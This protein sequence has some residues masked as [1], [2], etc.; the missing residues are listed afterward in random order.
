MNR[1]LLLIIPALL[2]GCGD[3]SAFQAP[4]SVPNGTGAQVRSNMNN[5]LQAITTEQSGASAPSTTYPYQ[6]WIDTSTTPPTERIRNAANTAWVAVGTVSAT[7]YTAGN[8]DTVDT[9]HASATPGNSIIPVGDSAGRIAWGAKPAFRG[10]LVYNTPGTT[11]L[12]GFNSEVYDTDN[13]HST[14]GETGWLVVPAGVSKIRITA[15]GRLESGASWRM[16]VLKNGSFF[17]GG[18]SA[19]A[20]TFYHNL[21]TPVLSVTAGDFFE[22]GASSMTADTTG[23]ECWFAMEI[24]E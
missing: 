1:L 6:K 2:F 4:I 12:A 11:G 15:Q 22:L 23:Q 24:I 14:T 20:S 21:V 10:A 8:A 17:T 13:I 3:S 9:Y 18:A 19:W 5:A 7:A 16:Y